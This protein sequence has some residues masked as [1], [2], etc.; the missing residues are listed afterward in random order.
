M[1]KHYEDIWCEAERIFSELYSN[2]YNVNDAIKEIIDNTQ[3]LQSSIVTENK[4][5][6]E[7]NIMT[8]MVGEI[9]FNLAIICKKFD[10]NSWTALERTINNVKIDLYDDD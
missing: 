10:I 1:V 6:N 8:D 7:L 2:K 3:K 5:D 4:L 9:L